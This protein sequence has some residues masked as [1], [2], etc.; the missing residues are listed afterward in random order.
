MPALSAASITKTASATHHDAASAALARRVLRHE[1]VFNGFSCEK[2]VQ[3]IVIDSRRGGEMSGGDLRQARTAKGWTQD[4]LA[5]RLDVSQAYVSLLESDRRPVPGP[6]VRKLVSILERPA[7]ALPV[8]SE[9][10][11]LPADGVARAL[12]TL[13]YAGFAHSVEGAS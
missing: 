9:S 4:D 8:G 10:S 1:F 6:L 12:G 3:Y 5:R 13:G 2:G 11:P 7:S